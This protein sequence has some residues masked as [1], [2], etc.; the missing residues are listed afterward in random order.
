MVAQFKQVLLLFA[1]AVLLA[2]AHVA[3][4]GVL[5]TDTIVADLKLSAKYKG[6]KVDLSHTVG[7][8]PTGVAWDGEEGVSVA[9]GLCLQ[10][11]PV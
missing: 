6:R 1:T 2:S 3:A 4:M 10:A 8:L 11:C 5:S 7:P 9:L